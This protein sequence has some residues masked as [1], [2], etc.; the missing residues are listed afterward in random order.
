[1]S[2]QRFSFFVPG[3][4]A[5]AG[6][7]RA[8]VNK[9]TGK[10][11][12]VDTCKSGPPWRES[13]RYH[14]LTAIAGMPI[15][16]VLI[17]E[18]IE[19]NVVFYFVRPKGHFRKSEKFKGQL[20]VTAPHWPT[21]R[22]DVTKMLRALEDALNGF[23]WRDDSL[24]VV[25]AARKVY[26]DRSGAYVTIAPSLYPSDYEPSQNASRM[27]AIMDGLTNEDGS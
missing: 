23:V 11:Q 16:N 26:A 18:P 24:V 20:N 5:T 25:Q 22:P 3:T 12:V 13:V 9:A 27:Q 6:S 14:A 4:P 15:E 10:A 8:F 2:F 17:D 19:L 7:K 21:K 1:M